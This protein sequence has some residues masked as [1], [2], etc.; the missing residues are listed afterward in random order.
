MVCPWGRVPYGS[1]AASQV[2]SYS[3][4]ACK[5]VKAFVKSDTQKL[6]AMGYADLDSETP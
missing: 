2:L 5:L 3:G 4:K 6:C 1:E